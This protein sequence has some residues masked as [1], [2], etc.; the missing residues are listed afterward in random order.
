MEEKQKADR[1]KKTDGSDDLI[2]CVGVNVCLSVIYNYQNILCAVEQPHLTRVEV[3]FLFFFSV[4][5]SYTFKSTRS[6]YLPLTFLWQHNPKLPLNTLLVE[7]SEHTHIHTHT[8]THI[9][10]H[11]HAD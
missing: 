8:H 5:N 9:Y 4:H 10:K 3:I 6:N 11:T 1:E 2:V 7:R